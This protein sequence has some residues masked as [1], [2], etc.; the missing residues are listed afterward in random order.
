MLI[1]CVSSTIFFQVLANMDEKEEKIVEA[2]VTAPQ[3]IQV[4][5]INY[6]FPSVVESWEI[7]HSTWLVYEKGKERKK[8]KTKLT[9][10]LKI[11]L[12]Y[13]AFLFL[14]V[15]VITLFI[16]SFWWVWET[17]GVAI[18]SAAGEKSPRD[19]S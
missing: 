4:R 9:K 12:T 16:C 10:L 13:R 2:P 18:S 5:D 15:I 3:L 14:L 11:P 6:F 19:Q 7:K 8:E 1:R 17:I